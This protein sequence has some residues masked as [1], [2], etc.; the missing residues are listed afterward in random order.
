MTPI[1]VLGKLK[2]IFE[3]KFGD[4][5]S[6]NKFVFIDFSKNSNDVIEIKDEKSLTLDPD[7]LKPEELKQI[8]ELLNKLVS[9]DDEVFLLNKP[10]ANTELI[11][12]K[13]NKG[14]SGDA[15]I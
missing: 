10:K 11:K 2:S 8:K 14:K 1:E 5:L 7:R 15:E 3:G 12:P 4:I 13:N 9:E 6:N